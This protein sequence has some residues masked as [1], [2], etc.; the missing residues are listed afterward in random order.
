MKNTSNDSHFYGVP[1]FVLPAVF[2]F[3]AISFIHLIF[4]A[5]FMIKVGITGGIGS[6][7]STVSN[8]FKVL[9]MPVFDADSASKKLM[10]EDETLKIALQK[11]FGKDVYIDGKLNRKYL[12][13]IVF[14]D[15]HHLEVLNNL[16]HPVSI[17]AGLEWAAKQTSPYIIKEAALMF[18]A[19]AG[20]N[21]DY[22]IGVYAPQA[23]RIKRVM[24]RD[25]VGRQDVLNRMSKQ[26]N[27]EMKMKLCDFV[28][29][30]D[31]QQLVTTQVIKLHEHFLKL[32]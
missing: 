13:E 9:G 1:F 25:G 16:V 32:V 26:I 29:V 14:K 17:Q 10:E 4:I 31:E 5:H 3:L 23:I 24:D 22:I 11:E 28:I 15:A 30:N 21:L 18:E 20:F 6:G 8:I 2:I 7:K 12:S 19:G 27:E